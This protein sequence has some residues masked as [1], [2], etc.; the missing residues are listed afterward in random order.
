MTKFRIVEVIENSGSADRKGY[1]IIEQNKFFGWKEIGHDEGPKYKSIIHKSYEEAELY[2][3]NN[4]TGHGVCRKYGNVYTY[5]P[6][7]YYM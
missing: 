1:W 3:L 6:Y 5:N 7:T 2:L 4:Y